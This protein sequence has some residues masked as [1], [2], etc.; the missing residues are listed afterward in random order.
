MDFEKLKNDLLKDFYQDP[1]NIKVSGKLVSAFMET[2][3]RQGALEILEKALD[4]EETEETLTNLGYFYLYEGKPI[5]A[6]DRW[7]YQVEKAINI[8]EKALRLNL[9]THMPYSVLGE[10]YLDKKRFTD[11]EIVL[12]KAINIKETVSNLNNLGVS[13]YHLQKFADARK[14][15]NKAHELGLASQEDYSFYPLLNYGLSLAKLGENKESLEIANAL[16]KGLKSEWDDPSL[17]DI[18]FLYFENSDY[19]K[20]IETFERA[21]PSYKLYPEFFSCH[22]YALIAEGLN[23]IAKQFFEKVLCTTYETIEDVK[24]DEDHDF[25]NEDKVAYIESLEKECRDYKDNYNIIIKG[26]KPGIDLYL[27]KIERDCYLFGC[28][29]HHPE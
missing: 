12:S 27:P 9:V 26:I 25:K 22:V 11:A 10:A 24:N 7:D 21:F 28:F 23:E 13:C 1:I 2:R 6:N 17:V 15:F 29:M 14:C 5:L 8:L 4:I 3:D 19:P 18:G 16:V 20:V